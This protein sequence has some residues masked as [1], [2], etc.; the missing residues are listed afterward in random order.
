MSL[1]FDGGQEGDVVVVNR[2][3]KCFRFLKNSALPQSISVNGY[4]RVIE[5]LTAICPK[6]GEI[7]LDWFRD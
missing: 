7:K 4:G 3:T 1:V 2:C 6:C 5:P